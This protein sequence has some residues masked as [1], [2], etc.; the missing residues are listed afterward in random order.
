MLIRQR[1]VVLIL[2]L[3]IGAALFIE[4]SNRSV[5][6]PAESSGLYPCADSD[7]TPYNPHC[8]E[9]MMGDASQLRPA[10]SN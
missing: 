3:V 4:L 9:F 8:I 2:A 5:I 10:V 1:N 7:A 6:E